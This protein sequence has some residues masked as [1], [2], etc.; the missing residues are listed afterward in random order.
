MLGSAFELAW[1]SRKSGFDQMFRVLHGG[2][3]NKNGG[4]RIH[5]TEKPITLMLQIIEKIYP[6]VGVVL[7]PFSGSGTTL[8]AAKDLR[9]KAIG[10]EIEERYCELTANRLRQEV[11]CL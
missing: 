1:T 8:R 4:K 2:V 3:V 5:P 6:D 11:L 10:I 7:D 9:K